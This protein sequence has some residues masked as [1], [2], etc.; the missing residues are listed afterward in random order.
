MNLAPGLTRYDELAVLDLSRREI[1]RVRSSI[2]D[3]RES[4]DAGRSFETPGP[5][6]DRF[7]FNTREIELLPN[8]VDEL[9]PA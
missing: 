7:G 2:C 1:Q 5:T 4:G 3:D 6:L 9:E 8:V